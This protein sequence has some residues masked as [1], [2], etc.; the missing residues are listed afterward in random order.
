MH[1]NA[2]VEAQIR[3]SG[4]DRDG[5]LGGTLPNSLTNRKRIR[6]R[7]INLTVRYRQFRRGIEHRFKNVE[8]MK[9]SQVKT[10]LILG[11][12]TT[13][14]LAMITWLLLLGI[15][16]GELLLFLAV[17][18]LFLPFIPLNLFLAVWY[19]AGKESYK[20]RVEKDEREGLGKLEEEGAGIIKDAMDELG[21]G[22]SDFARGLLKLGL[23]QFSQGDPRSIGSPLSIPEL[24]EIEK[25]VG[26]LGSGS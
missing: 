24:E 8:Y 7:S 16:R 5:T 17:S 6:D 9:L 23:A 11:V 20:R 1:A 26:L 19:R 18:F 21:V 13:V 4:I 2:R 3:A 15:T 22:D 10:F 14:C 12:L 25:Q